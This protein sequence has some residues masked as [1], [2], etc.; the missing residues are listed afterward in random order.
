MR[1]Y[2]PLLR[3]SSRR[4][5]MSLLTPPAPRGS[6]LGKRW[7]RHPAVAAP[8]S[9]S[10]A[11]A[12][13]P[14]SRSSRP[15]ASRSARRPG[16]RG[17]SPSSH[18]DRLSGRGLAPLSSWRA[19]FRPSSSNISRSCS[20]SE[21]SVVRK[22]P[23][24]TPLRPALTAS[25]WSSPWP[26]FSLRPPQR[27]N[28]ASG[29][30]SRKIATHLTASSGSIRSRSPNL[31]PGP[32]VQQVDR[33]GGGV[34]L[35]ELE[36]HLDALLVR[37]AQVEDASD[38]GLE[39]R[40]A[41]GVDRPE[42]ALVADGARD[43]GVVALRRLDVV[44]DA[45][46]A[47]VLQRVCARGGHVPDRDAALQVRVLGDEPCAGDDLL[48]VALREALALRDHAEA[49]RARGLGRARVLEDLVGIHHRVHRRV[50]LGE[51]RLRA[52]PA[53]LRAAARLG[54]D[55]R[56][57]VRRVAEAVE[58]DAP[59]AVDERLDLGAIRQLAEPKRLF[60]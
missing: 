33:H 34:H 52:E 18:P 20:G 32:G 35:R 10:C 42:P 24:I 1:R 8:S 43:L 56:A 11:E 60:P 53:V 22:L 26:R 46:D 19:T 3:M 44:V 5:W 58:P 6:P 54:V 51:A 48:E 25:C 30:I 37:L 59:G 40:V 23:I 4:S 15:P 41:H 16:C 13:L 57:H 28:R 27:R 9:S 47:G 45:L 55:E 31:V 38:A 39:A 17:V 7:V 2:S 29:M 12:G 36:R 21:P 14:G 50:G 49:V